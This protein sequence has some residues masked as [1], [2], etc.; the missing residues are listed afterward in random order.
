MLHPD[1]LPLLLSLNTAGAAAD[2]AGALVAAGAAVAADWLM[3]LRL[4]KKRSLLSRAVA[5]SF[6]RP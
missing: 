2:Q 5:L 4:S 6:M 3:H 1:S